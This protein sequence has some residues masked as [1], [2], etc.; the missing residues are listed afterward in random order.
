MEDTSQTKKYKGRRRTCLYR[1]REIVIVTCPTC[2][3]HRLAQY[4][5]WWRDNIPKLDCASCAH[6]KTYERKQPA[7]RLK[8]FDDMLDVLEIVQSFF[9]ATTPLMIKTP[10]NAMLKAY[11]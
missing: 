9:T 11:R 2:G 6:K 4:R 7:K 5:G 10:V 8:D 1:E 3:K